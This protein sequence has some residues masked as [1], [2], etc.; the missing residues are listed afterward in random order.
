MKYVTRFLH[1]FWSLIAA[2][3]SHT[4]RVYALLN[5]FAVNKRRERETAIGGP[6]LLYRPIHDDLSRVYTLQ[7]HIDPTLLYI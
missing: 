6:S 2:A 5:T 4:V 3:F 1:I 7:T